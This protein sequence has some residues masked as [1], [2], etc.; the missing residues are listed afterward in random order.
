MRKNEVTDHADC[1]P[2]TGYWSE[3]IEPLVKFPHV[4][5][6]LWKVFYTLIGRLL[7]SL[8]VSQPQVSV[9]GRDSILSASRWFEWTFWV[10]RF[11][12]ILYK[13]P[14]EKWVNM[15]KTGLIIR[16]FSHLGLFRIWVSTLYT[17]CY[18]YDTKMLYLQNIYHMY[19]NKGQYWYTR[20][21]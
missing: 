1:I 14:A 13:S 7:R 12:D 8:L 18:T 10:C 4:Q 16:E 3:E 5:Y 9:S 20:Y 17:R 15:T 19:N 21:S 6:W 11:F 2:T